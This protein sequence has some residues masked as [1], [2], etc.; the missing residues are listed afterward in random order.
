MN[1]SKTITAILLSV[2]NCIYSEEYV[3]R[4]R[5]NNAFTRSRKLSFSN[6][7]RY[8]I[9]S[10]HHSVSVNYSS[11]RNMIYDEKL[12]MVSKQALSKARQGISHKAFLNF[13]RIS[14]EEYYKHNKNTSLW[15]GFHLFAVDGTT[16]QIPVSE[17][18]LKTFGSNPNKYE[19]DTPLASVSAL[20]DITNDIL[21]DVNLKPYR[22]SERESAK[23]HM[24]YL[25]DKARSIVIF[26]RGYPSENL[27]RFLQ[28]RKIFFLMRVP[29]TFK[30]IIYDEADT[31]F[32]F[33]SNKNFDEITLR[34]IHFTLK[35]GKEE[36]LVT[37]LMP[38]QMP[39]SQFEALYF[40]R[41]GIESKYCE[42]K[43]RLEI[44][45]FNSLKPTCIKQEFYV[46]MFLSNLSAILKQEVDKKISSAPS[47]HNKK[48]TYQANRSYI[49]NRLKNNILILLKSTKS[50]I[51]K[52]IHILVEEAALIR[53]IVRPD[54]KYGRYRRHTRRKFY[55]HMKNCL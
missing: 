8:I 34:S 54:R 50:F 21:V 12:P 1:F 17:E 38:D 52:A 48:H 25:P 37:N 16:I 49:L 24:E 4:Y 53:S 9:H 28:Q 46:A 47:S 10:S 7:I 36:Y 15:N 30:K 42:L 19:K 31:L 5:I 6:I 39:Q 33:P 14:V 45:N 29:K 23:L 11:F 51:L 43:N 20:Y 3:N 40:F 32:T 18:N 13:F 2:S 27:F 44:E 26:D 41:W 55:S 22:F 35:S